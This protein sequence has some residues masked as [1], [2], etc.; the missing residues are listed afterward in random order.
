MKKNV[1]I[2]LIGIY[3]CT[4]TPCYASFNDDLNTSSDKPK[5]TKEPRETRQTEDL[6]IKEPREHPEVEKQERVEPEVKKWWQWERKKEE[7]DKDRQ[8]Q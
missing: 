4:C 6:K 5:L 2:L 7:K 8:K 3:I 1:A